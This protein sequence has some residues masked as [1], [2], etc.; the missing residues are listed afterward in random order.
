MSRLHVAVT[1]KA[2]GSCADHALGGVI[3]IQILSSLFVFT[4][5]I[6]QDGGVEGG[7]VAGGVAII[8]GHLTVLL[9]SGGVVACRQRDVGL[10]YGIVGRS[11]AGTAYGIDPYQDRT[12]YHSYGQ[13]HPHDGALAVLH[14][15]FEAGQRLVD[16]VKSRPR[17]IVI[18]LCHYSVILN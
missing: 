13:N 8:V 9:Q 12:H 18:V 10:T 15:L 1:L 14:F 5:L 4:I 6:E 17:L 11:H 2:L 3:L 7:T 16:L